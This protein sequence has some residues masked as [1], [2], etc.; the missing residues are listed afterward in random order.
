MP[1]VFFKGRSTTTN[2]SE[3][4]NYSLNAMDNGNHIEV[5]Y[6]DFSKVFDRID[7]PMLVFKLK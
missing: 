5:F 2:L 6:T 3:F 7:I 4:T 1:Q